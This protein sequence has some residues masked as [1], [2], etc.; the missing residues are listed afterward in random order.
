MHT[1]WKIIA[2]LATSVCMATCAQADWKKD[3]AEKLPLLGH[4]NWV[5]VADSAYPLQIAS[6]I[7]TIYVGGDH[8]GVVSDVL[9]LLAAQKHVRPV[10]FLDSELEHVPE[11]HAPGIDLV[12]S[13]LN[14]QLKGRGVQT[15]A[16]EAIIDQLDEAGETFRIVVIKTDLTLP[17]TSVFIRLD[18]GYWSA[19]AESALR[20]S[21]G[22]SKE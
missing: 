17:Y 10:I 6:G 15:L 4:R 20:D 18:C 9:E 13:G 16:H 21:M 7:E 2:L 22:K 11:K 1:L 3:L 14:S 8:V 19:E 12:R 5:V